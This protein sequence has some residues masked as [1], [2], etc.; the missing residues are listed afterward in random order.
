MN[1]II[2][3]LVAFAFSVGCM[4]GGINYDADVDD[5]DDTY[6]KIKAAG[7]TG[8][9]R[10]GH[11]ITEFYKCQF[12]RDTGKTVSCKI[13]TPD[14]LVAEN[15]SLVKQVSGGVGNA[16][17]GALVGDGIRDA[18]YGDNNT[19]NNSSGSVSNATGGA[20]GNG[21]LGGNGGNGGTGNGWGSP[22]NSGGS[23]PGC[24]NS[25]HC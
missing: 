24:E 15:D 21:G 8:V 6:I 13:M 16:A 4:H 1:K 18:D 3:V 23:H 5:F 11:E 9:V 22:G 17:N 19:I 12:D 20:G 2:L 14:P 25:G 10:Q 7:H